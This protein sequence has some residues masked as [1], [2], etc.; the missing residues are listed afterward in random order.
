MSAPRVYALPQNPENGNL[1]RRNFYLPDP[2]RRTLSFV[3]ARAS[4]A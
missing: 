2:L 3:T 4:C 1:Q